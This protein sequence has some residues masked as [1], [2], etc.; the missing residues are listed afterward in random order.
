MHIVKKNR[1]GPGLKFLREF[2]INFLIETNKNHM[3]IKSVLYYI[4]GEIRR[5]L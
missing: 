1:I 3:Y 4:E 2:H 5:K